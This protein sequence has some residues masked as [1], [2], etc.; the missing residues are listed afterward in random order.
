MS[1]EEL[2]SK[3][4]HQK[5][6]FIM[7]ALLLLLAAL[8]V[9]GWWW[10]FWRGVETTDDAFVDGD[11]SRIS[12]Q[13][14]GQVVAIEVNDNQYVK[15]GTP[16]VELDAR[17]KQINLHKAQAARAITEAKLQQNQA[18]QAAL[19]A[20][21]EKNQA[22]IEVAQAEYQRDEKEYLRY[23]Q[24]GNAVSKSDLDAKAATAKIS[25]AR[26]L[27]QQKNRLSGEAQL[28]KARAAKEEITATLQQNQAGI[29]SAQ[30]LLSY[31]K[32]NAPVAGYITK[33]TISVGNYVTAGSDLM[34]MI[35]QQVWVTANFKESQLRHMKP[36]QRVDL[37]I[38]AW[39]GHTFHGKVDS[40][41]RATG[42]VF[43]LLP[44]E[45]ATGNYVKI[46]QRVPVKIVFADN[47]IQ[48][49]PLAPGMSVVPRVYVTH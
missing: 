5:R 30:L 36:G 45:N 38:D 14:S 15:E 25:V 31:T 10:F 42:S 18:E 20:A 46:V 40:I 19:Q 32:I 4:Q 24:S 12:S 35:S 21:L 11:I 26:L 8:L 37:N 41:Q 49:Y 17:D 33:R 3:Q 43:S 13:I 16:L 39:P 2:T 23:L 28:R 34:A 6:V 1:E 7:F 48:N 9:V 22:D 47:E 27:A 29:A 44:A